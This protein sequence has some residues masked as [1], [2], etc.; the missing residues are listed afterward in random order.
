[1]NYFLE[2]EVSG[3]AIYLDYSNL[4]RSLDKE[5]IQSPRGK[6]LIEKLAH[7]DTPTTAILMTFP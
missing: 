7:S 6:T 5:N 1:V 2:L 4:F 3:G